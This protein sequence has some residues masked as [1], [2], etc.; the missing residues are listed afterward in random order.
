MERIAVV[1]D[2]NRSDTFGADGLQQCR[3]RTWFPSSEARLHLHAIL[4]QDGVQSSRGRIIVSVSL[5]IVNFRLRRDW[6]IPTRSPVS[7]S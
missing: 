5:D 3:H 4:A 1:Q 2:E 7:N 6:V